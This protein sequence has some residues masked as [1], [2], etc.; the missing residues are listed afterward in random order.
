MGSD[1]ENVSQPS[2][3]SAKGPLFWLV[4]PPNAIQGVE[5]RQQARLIS[6]FIL[7]IFVFASFGLVITSIQH[8]SD[9]K[10][11][12]DLLA[13]L[14]LVIL[15]AYG[16]SRT[17][18]NSI[19]G[20]LA[21][22]IVSIY[23]FSVIITSH[24][25]DNVLL[26]LMWLI[27]P[28]I[29]STVLLSFPNQVLLVVIDVLGIIV[30]AVI[31]PQIAYRHLLLT[32]GLIVSTS[33]TSIGL[34]IYQQRI[35]GKQ[36][37][38]LH[39]SIQAL[40]SIRDELRT[41]VAEAVH[42]AAEFKAEAEDAY[43]ALKAQTWQTSGISELGKVMR[44]L[45]TIPSLTS[46]IM[47]QVCRYTD[48]PV[49]AFFLTEGDT[50]CLVGSYAY[51]FPTSPP[52]RFR[53]G[54]G[55]VGEAAR[56]Q[57]VITM[58]D[59]PDNYLPITSGL[60]EAKPAQIIA[61]PCIYQEHVIGVMELASLEPFTAAQIQ[62]ITASMEFI[63]S[64]LNGAQIR[65]IIDALLIDTR[66]QTEELLIQKQEH[67]QAASELEQREADLLRREKLFIEQKNRLDAMTAGSKGKD[68][69]M[70]GK[71]EAPD[72]D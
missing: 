13:A 57:Q 52:P 69:A 60:G 67:Q 12:A 58:R 7:A 51:P 4:E 21:F 65:V 10:V 33:V 54:S 6:V 35:G 37:S 36:Q 28:I 59:I 55:L 30:L 63:A 9:G 71:I 25:Y 24:L 61:V 42:S 40:E 22:T 16:F 20:I 5:N 19:A 56:E 31:G 45:Q 49:G 18:Y 39:Q 62:F 15:F 11:N 72:A 1:R 3:L 44:G 38:G 27:L 64:A 66:Q 46:S 14:T 23:P 50:L 48:V 8:A 70:Q 34:A 68:S 2:H 29:L 17:R 41:Q 32:A 47:K 43:S 53:L 26:S